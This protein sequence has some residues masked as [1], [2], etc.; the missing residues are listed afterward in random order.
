MLQLRKLA[1]LVGKA[2]EFLL[3]VTDQEVGFSMR[4]NADLNERLISNRSNLIEKRLRTDDIGI[5]EN[6]RKQMRLFRDLEAP[7]DSCI[8]QLVEILIAAFRGN[9]VLTGNPS[10]AGSDRGLL[11]VFGLR[12]PA[13]TWRRI[14]RSGSEE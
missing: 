11:H 8:A 14:E 3:G 4:L 1:E 7:T 13:V 2:A 5:H 9:M 10:A 6:S 12:R